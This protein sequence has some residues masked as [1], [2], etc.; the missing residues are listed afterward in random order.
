MTEI[1]ADDIRK[2]IARYLA[3]EEPVDIGKSFGIDGSNVRFY[4]AKS[5]NLWV[6][7]KLYAEVSQKAKNARAT[8]SKNKWN[9]AATKLQNRIA[10][11][12]ANHRSQPA[13]D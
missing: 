10:Y 13:S 5:S 2:I 6:L 12:Q 3:G 9:D 1:T 8:V 7:K 11:L 4:L